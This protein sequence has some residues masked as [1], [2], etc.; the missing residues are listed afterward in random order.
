MKPWSRWQDWAKLVV[1]A[2]LL[3]S[4]WVLGTVID[5][6]SS[7]NAW[8]VGVLIAAVSLVNLLAPENVRTEWA[9]LGLGTWLFL[10]PWI[11]GFTAFANA[12]RNAWIVG[13]L[14][15]ILAGLALPVARRAPGRSP[16]PI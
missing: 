16:S 8:I 11:L 14:V 12:A 15:V 4:P 3:A 5:P 7:W 13:V 2:W 6:S 1:G 10:S 9:S